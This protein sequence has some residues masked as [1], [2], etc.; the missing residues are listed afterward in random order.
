MLQ[1]IFSFGWRTSLTDQTTQPMWP[2]HLV[3]CFLVAVNFG[4]LHSKRVSGTFALSD[5]HT[6]AFFFVDIFRFRARGS[7]QDELR[8]DASMV[9]WFLGEFCAFFKRTSS[10]HGNRHKPS[11]P[12]SYCWRNQQWCGNGGDSGRRLTE[13]FQLGLLTWRR[14]SKGENK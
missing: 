1:T 11:C 4:I 7:S 5:S 2:E 9:I 14:S 3:K 13:F 8:G 6:Y 12:R 10:S